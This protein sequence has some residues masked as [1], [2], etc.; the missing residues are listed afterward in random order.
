MPNLD[1]SLS[2]PKTGSPVPTLC[3]VHSTDT[4]GNYGNPQFRGN[5]SGELIKDVLQ[6]FAPNT[7]LDPMEGSG[8]CRDVCKELKIDYYGFDLTNGIDA[9]RPRN[10]IGCDV[11]FVWL[12]R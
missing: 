12:L 9:R 5:C 6:F 7:C 11:D 3:S 1:V 2:I 4:R 8:T 10:F